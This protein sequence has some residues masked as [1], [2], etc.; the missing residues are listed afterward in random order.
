[1]ERVLDYLDFAVDARQSG[2]VRHKIK[3][4]IALT[5]FAYPANAEKW[6]DAETFGKEHGKF[7]RQYPEPPCGM[8]SRDTIQRVFASVSPEFPQGFRQKWHE[9]MNGDEGEKVRKLL[10]IDGK[11]GDGSDLLTILKNYGIMSLNLNFAR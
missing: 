5:F 3:D 6:E 8:P 2:K 11:T 7:L 9:A 4:C 10:S 1:M